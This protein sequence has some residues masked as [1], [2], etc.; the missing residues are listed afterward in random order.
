MSNTEKIKDLRVLTQ[1]GM[2]D[3]KEALEESNWDLDKAV[4]LI[5]TKGK[6]VS[7]GNKVAAEGL[8]GAIFIGDD[9]TAGLI[10]VNCITDFVAKSEGFQKFSV[11]AT[12]HLCAAT[13]VNAPFQPKNCEELENARQNLTATTKENIVVRRWWVEQ[14]FDKNGRVFVY[15]HPNADHGKIGVMVSLL[16]P[17]QE[18]LNSDEFNKLGINLALQVAAMNPLTVSSDK[19]DASI[20]NRQVAI[21]Q[22]QIDAM[23]K[24]QASHT[25][26]LE[27]KMNKWYTEVCLLNQESVVF[28]KTTVEQMIKNVNADIQVINFIRCQVGEGIEKPVDNFVDEV[29]KMTGDK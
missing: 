5:K 17:T 7:A 12:Q 18:V 16:A 6:L 29:L 11:L 14:V 21:F 4:D 13:L 3:C 27:G 28:P 2:K 24:P 20:F 15:V 26:I 8:V 1:A 23:N 25:K 22:S 9:R 10:E 19:L